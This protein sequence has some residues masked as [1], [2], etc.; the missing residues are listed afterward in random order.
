[1]NVNLVHKMA[2]PIKKGWSFNAHWSTKFPFSGLLNLS[3]KISALEKLL[4]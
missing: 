4:G 3:N 2:T 1:M